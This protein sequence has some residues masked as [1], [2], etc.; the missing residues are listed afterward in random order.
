MMVAKVYPDLKFRFVWLVIGYALVALVLYL[1]LTSNPVN[2]KV[3]M[4][5]ADKFFHAL[6]YFSLM[7]WF[8]QL[9]H[10]KFQRYMIALGLI[11]LGVA[12]EYLQSFDP[13]RMSELADMAANT[14]GVVLA[15]SLTLTKAK[16]CL[17]S[18]ENWIS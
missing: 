3:T 4:P 2:V 5:F 15:F 16:N 18:I 17:V 1:S 6:A 11:L 12:L 8:A 7:V 10:D 13:A 9:Y 14:T